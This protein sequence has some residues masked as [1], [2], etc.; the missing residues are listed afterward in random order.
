VSH[1]SGEQNLNSSIENLEYHFTEAFRLLSERQ[2]ARIAF[3]EGHGELGEGAV[4]DI[5]T[6]LS[7]YYSVDRGRIGDDASILDNYKAVIVA[8]PI[9]AFT[10]SDKYV[11]DQYVMNG[12]KLLWLVDGVK[13]AM[14]SLTK[15]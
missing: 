9:Q 5:T 14:E 11:L 10:E 8:Q 7:Q 15:A 13:M 1:K 3:L 6:A 2:E 4:Y 12:G